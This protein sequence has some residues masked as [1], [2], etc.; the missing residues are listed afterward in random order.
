MAQNDTNST[1]GAGTDSI[2]V[3]G[4]GATQGST[5]G[6]YTPSQG[7]SQGASS[8]AGQQNAGGYAQQAQQAAQQLG[9]KAQ[10]AA[11]QL[12]DKAASTYADVKDQATDRLGQVR[13]Q[14]GQ[15]K[16]TVADKLDQG[17]QALRQQAQPGGG[18]QLAGAAG[19]IVNADQVQRFAGPT[20]DAMEKTADFL[21]SGDLRG[22]IEDQVR[23][24]P[25]RTLLIALGLG[26]VVGKAIRR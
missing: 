2:S 15:L 24:N 26:Y 10:Q 7:G 5:S 11:Q 18:Q 3:T 17:A 25:G 6:G 20:A 13:E 9:D 4:A 1:L 23:T 21:R 8:G 19:G 16:N 22:A 14:A 12:G